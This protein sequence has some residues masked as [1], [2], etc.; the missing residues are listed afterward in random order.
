M[1]WTF[2]VEF[3]SRAKLKQQ[4]AVEMDYCVIWLVRI[5]AHQDIKWEREWIS[6]EGCKLDTFIVHPKNGAVT[7]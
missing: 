4:N 2:R 6:T 3:W 7:I 1:T 5:G